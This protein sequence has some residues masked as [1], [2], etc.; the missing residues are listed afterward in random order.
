M[1]FTLH[2]QAKSYTAKLEFLSDTKVIRNTG[3]PDSQ[4]ATYSDVIA[5]NIASVNICA[6][7]HIKR[8][9]QKYASH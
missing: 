1:Q 9:R 5:V 8:W 3:G 4:G 7:M 6:N 2:L